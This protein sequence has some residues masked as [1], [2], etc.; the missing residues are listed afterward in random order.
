MSNAPEEFEKLRK[1][2]KLKRH[3]QPPPGYFNNFSTK[4]T[5]RIEAH[6]EPQGRMW[7]EAPWLK[8]FLVMMETN[9]MVA[10]VFG[11][12]A[13]GLLIS[14]I[15]WSQYRPPVDYS[16]DGSSVTL[17]VADAGPA[18]S[19]PDW[20]KS[21]STDAIAPSTNPM[22]STNVP[23]ALFGGLDTLSVQQVNFSTAH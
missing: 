17:A 19:G 23:G 22:F 4:V 21:S 13:C 12:S 7:N 15:A 2:L 8:K 3:E 10:G 9:P 6:N 16:A 18:A 11:I 1:L 14:G 20:N 5:N